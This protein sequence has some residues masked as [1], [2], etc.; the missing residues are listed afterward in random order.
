M[1][2]E[3]QM[4]VVL[5]RVTTNSEK[6]AELVRIAEELAC[7]SCEDGGCISYRVFEDIEREN[8]FVFIEEWESEQALQRHFATPH[9][10]EFMGAV[11]DTVAGPP[12]VKFHTVARS[13]DL[14]EVNVVS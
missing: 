12:D 11:F 14:A 1:R 2:E 8:E 4:I 3:M 9:V 6:R 7:S 13:V 10:A 5:G